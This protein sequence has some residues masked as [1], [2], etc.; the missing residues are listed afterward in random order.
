M[1]A[2]SSAAFQISAP[3]AFSFCFRLKTPPTS[4]AI[5][6]A[7]AAGYF[8]CTAGSAPWSAE[9][10]AYWPK[11]PRVATRT[12]SQNLTDHKQSPMNR[13]NR[14]VLR[15]FK[16]VPELRWERTSAGQLVLQQELLK[17]FA[18][19]PPFAPSLGDSRT[20]PSC[21]WTGQSALFIETLFVI[22]LI[23]IRCN[24]INGL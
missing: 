12:W 20:S 3:S 22:L 6:S 15:R 5:L 23:S 4:R 11:Q 10:A 1:Y 18:F 2:F 13:A 24:T 17:G 8:F 19:A 7:A 21:G 14:P 16:D 9:A